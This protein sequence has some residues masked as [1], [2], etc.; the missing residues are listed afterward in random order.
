MQVQ[1]NVNAANFL[2]VGMNASKTNGQNDK[3]EGMDFASFLNTS[4]Q[5]KSQ[6]LDALNVGAVN[7]SQRT[8][9][10]RSKSLNQVDQGNKRTTADSSRSG[11]DNAIQKTQEVSNNDTGE[12]VL[13]EE[14]FPEEE[15]EKAYEVLADV[16]TMFMNQFNLT[17]EEIETSMERIGLN[18][19]DLLTEDGVKSL[20]LELSGAEVS[21]VLTDEALR[22][23]LF[24]FVEDVNQIL[25]E[26]P[27]AIDE[28]PVDELKMKYKEH[29]DQQ[30][31][32]TDQTDYAP[33]ESYMNDSYEKDNGEP[34]VELKL[35]QQSQS[36]SAKADE[37]HSDRTSNTEKQ[38][39]ENP[40]LQG[41]ADA[42]DQVE[43]FP[44]VSNTSSVRSTDVVEQIVEQVRVNINQEN[45]SLEMQLYPEHLG[46][47]Q[48]H[49]VSK[50]GVMTA[51]I[52]AE[53]EAAKQAIE[54]GLANLKESLQG[55]NLK[56][57][58]IEVMVS[59]TGFAE[60]DERQDQYEGQDAGRGN[61][62]NHNFSDI[63]EANS[64]EESETERMRA[65]GSS[66]SYR[67]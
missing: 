20:F 60:S 38:H 18:M 36:G 14:E 23:E 59:T 67:A 26:Q 40:I 41:I 48:I 51:R 19:N 29:L 45:T 33:H 49:V 50:D 46:R 27:L 53:T 63:N 7:K 6:E 44:G 8:G 32:D 61:R 3:A 15:L 54:A 4:G 37:K 22:T 25:E 13:S 9:I 47:I 65:E 58:A 35:D 64:D 39:F 1:E 24:D 57:D 5:K 16:V 21:Q 52:A 42:V 56:V 34:T 11:K 62:R 30:A 2:S 28:I 12:A 55:Q 17:A 31:V 66:V 43:D 10:D